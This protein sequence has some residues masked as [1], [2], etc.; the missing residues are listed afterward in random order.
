MRTRKTLRVI[1]LSFVVL[2]SGLSVAP[3]CADTLRLRGS[4]ASFPFPLYL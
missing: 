4:G 1:L 3:V 2:W